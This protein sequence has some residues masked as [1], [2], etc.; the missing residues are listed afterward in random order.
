[1]TT[2]TLTQ[3][4]DRVVGMLT[5]L[6]GRMVRHESF[7]L[8]SDINDSSRVLVV[9]SGDLTEL[10]FFAPVLNHLKRRY[11]GMRITVLVRE[12]NGELIRTLEPISEMI[13]YEPEHLSLFSSTF[14][15]LLRRL[16]GRAFNVV[17]LLGH[18]FSFARSLTALASNARLRVG[19]S[20]RFTYPF[21]NCEIR[22]GE[23]GQYEAPRALS[24]L[25]VLGQSPGDSILGWRLPD[26]DI[27]WATQ[28]IHFRKPDKDTLLIAVDPGM[29]KGNHRLV[30]TAMAHLASEVARRHGGKLLLL[31]NNLDRKGMERFRSLVNGTVVDIEP[32][33]VKEALAL[34]SRAD[35][36][37]AGNTDYF[38][39]AVSM[40]R[41]TIGFFTRFDAPNWFPKSAPHVQIIQGVRGQKVS[42]D[43]VC[44]KIDTL[45]QL[46]SR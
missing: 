10:L 42:V 28:M 1:M 21:V 29:G 32:K 38:H 4:R 39:F 20:Q 33:N 25:S 44:S 41:P 11:P 30:D 9:D 12:G 22:V 34:L 43:E 8:P 27:R 19:F 17:F 45:L 26:A 35:L 36:V 6:L 7:S 14:F 2:T 46:T 18:E 15:A 3:R 23:S 31:S 37:L 16:R 40:R 13:S 5:P 24:F